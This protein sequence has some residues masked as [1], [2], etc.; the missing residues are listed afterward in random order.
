[1]QELERVVLASNNLNKLTELR[2]LLADRLA[3]IPQSEFNV[4]E[5]EETGLTFV[6][7]SL[8]K[9]R[10]ASL[11]TGLPAVADDSGLQVDFLDGAPGI[12]SARYAGGDATDQDNRRKLI[13]EMASAP[14][15]Q[16]TA[17]FHCA[18][19]MLR[20]PDDAT[21]I[22]CEASWD[23]SILSHPKGSNGFGY[24][25]LF[26][27]AEFG[28]SAAELAPEVK[29]RISHRGQALTKLLDRVS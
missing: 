9:A 2:A 18:I 5:A 4:K 22:I 14:A 6:E 25:P 24:D 12:H 20:R 13:L 11:Q 15:A 7:N 16:R 8:I 29:N 28:C 21:P 1:M 17:R 19:V 10:N 3:V 23:G 27:V 26:L